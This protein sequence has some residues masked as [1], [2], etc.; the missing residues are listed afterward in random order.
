M[1]RTRLP[2]ASTRADKELKGK[3]AAQ[4][5]ETN[6]EQITDEQPELADT[7]KL[8]MFAIEQLQKSQGSDLLTNHPDGL[9]YVL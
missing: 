9:W 4:L 7:A 6:E 1:P 8:V 3:L 2:R 5:K